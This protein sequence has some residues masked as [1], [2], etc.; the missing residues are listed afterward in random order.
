VSPTIRSRV[1]TAVV[2]VVA[3]LLWYGLTSG[4]VERARTSCTDRGGQVTLDLDERGVS[5]VQW[6][7][8]PD[9]TRER[10]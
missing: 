7:V 1:L 6:C 4:R 5:Y 10:I 3:V 2:V 8:L 9:G